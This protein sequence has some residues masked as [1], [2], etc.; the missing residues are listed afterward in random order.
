MY[1][2][3]SKENGTKKKTVH[4][5]TPKW[6]RRYSRVLF[7]I[8]TSSNGWS[9]MP[10]FSLYPL[11]SPYVCSGLVQPTSNEISC[12]RLIILKQVQEL[13]SVVHVDILLRQLCWVNTIRFNQTASQSPPICLLSLNSLIRRPKK[14][15]FEQIK[16]FQEFPSSNRFVI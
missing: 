13:R 16:E 2:R 14:K 9:L 4:L 15:K 3:M 7:F 12:S 5:S 6:S 1:K 8:L 10:Y 11:S